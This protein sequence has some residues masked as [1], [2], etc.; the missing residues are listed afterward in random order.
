[1][2]FERED[3]KKSEMKKLHWGIEFPTLMFSMGNRHA[4]KQ[5]SPYCIY[6]PHNVPILG[7]GLLSLSHLQ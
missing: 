5:T 2:E 3:N 6:F 1:M 4:G 7:W